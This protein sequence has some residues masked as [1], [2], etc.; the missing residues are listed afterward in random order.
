MAYFVRNEA[1]WNDMTRNPN[2]LIGS[3]FKRKGEMLEQ[4]A[5]QQVGKKTHALQRSINNTMYYGGAGFVVRVGSDNPIALL[6]HEGTKP[7]TIL[8]KSAKTLRF[9]SHGKIVYAKVVHHPGTRPNKY[10]TDN[11]RKVIR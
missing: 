4:L 6:H 10:L 7:H 1:G 5:K 9:N 2:G 3:Y 11:L 8:P